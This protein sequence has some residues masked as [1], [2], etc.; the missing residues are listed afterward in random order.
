[1]I[2]TAQEIVEGLALDN[3]FVSNAQV[4]TVL[5]TINEQEFI[6]QITDDFNTKYEFVVWDQNSPVNG[7]A[8]PDVISRWVAIG[9]WDGVSPIYFIREIES[10]QIIHMQGMTPFSEGQVPL[11][12]NTI[13]SIMGWHKAIIIQD[14]IK[15]DL[16]SVMFQAFG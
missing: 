6:Q 8:A 15:S 16:M 9:F 13:Q 5:S 3:I 14:K 12:V 10:G 11:D 7:V 1:M 4:E 2:L